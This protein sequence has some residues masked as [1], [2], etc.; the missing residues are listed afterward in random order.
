VTIRVVV[1]DDQALVRAGLA[2]IIGSAPDLTVVAQAAD[3]REA[4]E[5]AEQHRPAVILM[6][7]RMPVLDGIAATGV[8]TKFSDPPRVLILTTFD[9]DEYVYA[10]LRAGAS[11]FLL[12]DTAPAE[13]LAGIRIVA[14]G[15]ALLAPRITRRLIARFAE[16]PATMLPAALRG[17]TDRE[18]EVLLLVAEGLSN[19]EIGQ[20]LHITAGTAKT[21]VARLLTKLDARDRIQLVILAHRQGLTR[22]DSQLI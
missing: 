9:L 16:H 10:A 11:G 12:K 3:G 2:G 17:I 1:C 4:I 5:C 20:R 22:P 8:I 6:D 15:D 18:R 13:L 7:V 19:L 21:H 14:A